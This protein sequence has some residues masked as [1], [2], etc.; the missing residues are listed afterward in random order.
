MIYS[1]CIRMTPSRIVLNEKIL[2][3]ESSGKDLPV[4]I[5][6]KMIGDWPKFFKMDPLSRV[7]FVASELLLSSE[8]PHRRDCEDRAILLYNRSG[9]LADDRIYES[10]IR[11]RDEF[12]PSPAVFVYT[13]P[14]IVT[15][16][17]AIRNKYYGETSFCVLDGFD[18][19]TMLRGLEAAFQDPRTL[20]AIFGWVEVESEE[21]YNVCLF[22]VHRDGEGLPEL[23]EKEFERIWKI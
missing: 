3:F 15:G 6:R 5:Y 12:Y 13:L 11:S 22:L 4:E 9:S 23:N 17:I 16:E 19:G 7:G 10:T 2:T 14:N 8:N 18:P 20:S 21:K 1:S